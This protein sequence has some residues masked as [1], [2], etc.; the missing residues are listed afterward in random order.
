MTE[1]PVYLDHHAHTP[2]DPHVRTVL[3]RSWDDFDLNVHAASSETALQAVEDARLQVAELLGVAPAEILFTSGATEANNLAILGLAEHLRRTGR[4]RIIVSAGE[5]PSVGETVGSL[6]PDFEVIVCPLLP[7]GEID[8]VKLE[9]LVT[10]ETG[11]ISIAAANHEIGTIQPLKAIADLAAARGALVHTDLAQA[12][13]KIA[14][15]LTGVHLASVSAHKIYGPLGVGALMVRRP[16]RRVLRPLLHGGGQE[17]GL[18]PG[19]LPAPLCV[20]FGAACHRARELF[21]SEGQRLTELRTRLIER[22]AEGFPAVRVNGRLDR[23]LPGNLNLCFPGV[24]AEALAMRLRDRVTVAT[25]SACN[26]RS[27]EPS[28]VLSAIGLSRADAESSIRIGLGRNTTAP[29]VD[30]AAE[31]IALAARELTA[32]RARAHA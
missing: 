21:H 18:R 8:L 13:G 16:V 5:H 27:L 30:F 32:I 15:D 29:D 24:D 17:G 26:A 31:Q 19:T 4:R 14:L 20:A 2:L 22:V 7:S 3:L 23:R 6:Q 25:G 9:A 1:S 12:F 11:L 10:D 28:H